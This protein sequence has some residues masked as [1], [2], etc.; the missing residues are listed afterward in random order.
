MIKSVFTSLQSSTATFPRWVT[1]GSMG[2]STMMT[3][4]RDAGLSDLV[5]GDEVETLATGLQFTEGPLWCPDGSLLF[6]DIKAERTY[7][8]RP[9]GSPAVLRDE[10]RA[11][12]GQTF[13]SDGGIVFCEQ[14]GRRVSRMSVEGT[15]VETVV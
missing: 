2:T 13:A 6:Q 11:A 14:N 4:L 5:R 12:N 7:R 10:T 8:L 9:G 3:I 1:N 15:G